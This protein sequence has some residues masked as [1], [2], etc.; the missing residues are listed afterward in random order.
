MMKKTVLAMM[1]TGVI[2]AAFM[3]P[4]F[5]GACGAMGGNILEDAF[6]IVAMVAMTPLIAIEALGVVYRL[7][8]RGK[9]AAPVPAAADDE[10]I[11]V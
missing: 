10:I 6:G 2:T 3:L 9:K 5:M 8:N 4:L 1:L 7:K 11:D